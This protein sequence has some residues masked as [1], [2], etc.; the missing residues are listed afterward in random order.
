VGGGRAA[1]VQLIESLLDR[2]FS[3]S[4]DQ[5]PGL[6]SETE[7][8]VL[9]KFCGTYRSTR[10]NHTSIEKIGQLF[11][12]AKVQTING[13]RLLISSGS[14]QSQWIQLQPLLFQ[15]VRSQEKI[16]FREDPEGNITHLFLRDTP[17]FALVK[18]QWH[19]TPLFHFFILGLTVFM[20][21]T[22]VFWPLGAL[23]RRIC[24]PLDDQPDAPKSF[25]LTAGIMS[26]LC[27]LFLI[28]LFAVFSRPE[29]IMYGIPFSL[30]ILLTLPFIALVLAVGVLIFS[31][32]VWI[33]NYWSWCSRVYYLL[34]LFA[35]VA[36]LWFLNYW[37]LLGYQF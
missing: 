2:Y 26:G 30:N 9:G 31:V 12:T 6:N 1:R 11:S 7:S 29:Q 24:R 25:R 32:I 36:F 3:V 37:N 15:K 18:L 19:E 4:G 28:G 20:F 14:S 35:F 27:V 16:L 34:V 8:P 10:V 13:Q 17:H 33:K 23:R 22:T 21:L 5:E